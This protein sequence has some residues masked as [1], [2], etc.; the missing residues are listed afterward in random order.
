M[1][2]SHA[3]KRLALWLPSQDWRWAVVGAL[4]AAVLVSLLVAVMN[5]NAAQARSSRELAELNA[6]ERARC[7]ALRNRL[8]RDQCLLDLRLGNQAQTSQR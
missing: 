5:E 7:A 1:T 8:E 3:G 6:L 2:N 4:M